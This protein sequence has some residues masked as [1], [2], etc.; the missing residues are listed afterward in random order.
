MLLN[1]SSYKGRLNNPEGNLVIE[2]FWIFRK[3]NFF[4]PNMH[5]GISVKLFP[6]RFS[7]EI[8]F[9]FY[10]VDGSWSKPQLSKNSYYKFIRFPI[11][12]E[13]IPILFWLKLS[14]LSWIKPNRS[15]GNLVSPIFPKSSY[16][17]LVKTVQ[18]STLAALIMT[19][20]I[21]FC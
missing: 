14:F 8:L 6:A 15:S 19:S 2:L 4:I 21:I 11:L 10:I 9:S 5:L 7:R 18:F 17:K 13:I 12:A 3:N 20:F 1:S 16:V